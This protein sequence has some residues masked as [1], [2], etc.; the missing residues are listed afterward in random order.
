M[1]RSP[2]AI[3]W[4]SVAA[5]LFSAACSANNGPAE[6]AGGACPTNGGLTVTASARIT[7]TCTIAGDLTI[8]G[9]AT[10]D[11]D[12]TADPGASLSVLGNVTVADSAVL[13]IQGGTFIIVNDRNGQRT[14][15]ARD[16]AQ[17]QFD[18]ISFRTIPIG[19]TRTRR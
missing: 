7:A 3:G 17:I 13:R 5:L 1:V 14:L 19:A 10:L 6:P 4:I 18:G 2:A 16:R 12:F 11:V 15:L 9:S 8:L